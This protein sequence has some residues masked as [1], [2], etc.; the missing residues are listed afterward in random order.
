[1]PRAL[2]GD[3]RAAIDLVGRDFAPGAISPDT[4]ELLRADFSDA[5]I[6]RFD[7]AARDLA[8]AGFAVERIPV[9]PFDDKTYITYTNGVYET[10]GGARVVYLPQ[11]G[12]ARMDAVAR[13]KYAALG[14]SVKPVRVEAPW[15]YHGT[16]GCLVNVLAR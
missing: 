14:W 1:V 11:Y 12:I 8:A 15:P 4:G 3:P 10:K 13:E 7:R 6:A 2:V 5:S 9:V 16:I